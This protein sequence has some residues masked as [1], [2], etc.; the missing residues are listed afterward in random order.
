MECWCSEVGVA[1]CFAWRNHRRLSYSG[2]WALTILWLHVLCLPLY[3]RF[4]KGRRNP[5][6]Y[7]SPTS[8][9]LVQH[10]EFRK[11]SMKNICLLLLSVCLHFLRDKMWRKKNAGLSLRI[12]GLGRRKEKIHKVSEIKIMKSSS[13]STIINSD[14]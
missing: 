8:W 4:I 14:K 13:K 12:Q 2:T 10:F 9:H 6:I 11:N 7:S 3:S 1:A 5:V